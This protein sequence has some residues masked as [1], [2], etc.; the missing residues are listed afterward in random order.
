MTKTVPKEKAPMPF[1]LARG[2]LLLCLFVLDT[3]VHRWARF[4]FGSI[5]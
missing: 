1:A 3:A 4:H 5:A 2:F